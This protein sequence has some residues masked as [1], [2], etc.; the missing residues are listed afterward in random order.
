MERVEETI[1]TK[2]LVDHLLSINTEN[3]TLSKIRCQELANDIKN[4]GWRRI[5]SIA[6]SENGI[7]ADGQHRLTA[8]RLAN[9]YNVPVTIL[10]DAT[11]E[12]M[13]RIDRNRPRSAKDITDRL[14]LKLNNCQI[15]AINTDIKFDHKKFAFNRV[16]VEPYQTLELYN[17]KWEKIFEEM[18]LLY[19][20][21]KNVPRAMRLA[22]PYICVI[23]N[24]GYYASYNDA[25]EFLEGVIGVSNNPP[26]QSARLRDY[27]I[28]TTGYEGGQTT[29]LTKI[30][31]A[32]YCVNAHYRG[33]NID[34]LRE[35]NK[36]EINIGEK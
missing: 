30:K 28:A 36:W 1:L 5:G 11:E 7:L 23:G 32:V 8:L 2:E 15:G 9:I 33:A 20:V 21:L 18:P 29:M 4:N 19:S 17:S 27:I 13:Q 14:G 22:S 12:T 24:Y 6:I 16:N 10:W 34:R 3:R 31:R 25:N 26:M 35:A